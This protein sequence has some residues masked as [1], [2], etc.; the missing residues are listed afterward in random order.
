MEVKQI[1]DMDMVAN[2]KCMLERVGAKILEVGK[3]KPKAKELMSDFSLKYDTLL[4][5]TK[6]KDKVI[7][8]IFIMCCHVHQ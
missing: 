1:T 5:D 6:E 8:S 3:K 7:Y 2:M 4:E